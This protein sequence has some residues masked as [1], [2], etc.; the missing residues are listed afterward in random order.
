MAEKLQESMASSPQTS[1]GAQEED[2]EAVGSLPGWSGLQEGTNSYLHPS[3]WRRR[4]TRGK[5]K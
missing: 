1:S 4:R 5:K 3:P 2:Q